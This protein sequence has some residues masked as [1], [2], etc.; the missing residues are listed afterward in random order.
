VFA[1][2]YTR[3]MSWLSWR[4][5]SRAAQLSAALVTQRCQVC[6]ALTG[7]SAHCALLAA[8][9]RRHGPRLEGRP[10]VVAC[11]REHLE[12]LTYTANNVT[13]LGPKALP[14]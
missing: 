3:C 6:G 9:D 2:G 12:K 5:R 8:D 13:A 4:D 1:A 14:E 10:L 7:S 11:S